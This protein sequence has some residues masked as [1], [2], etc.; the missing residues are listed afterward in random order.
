[1]WIK[2]MQPHPWVTHARSPLNLWLILVPSKFTTVDSLRMSYP[3]LEK[4]IHRFFGLSIY[5]EDRPLPPIYG[6]L[7][8]GLIQPFEP[9]FGLLSTAGG[10]FPQFLDSYP[11]FGGSKKGYCLDNTPHIWANR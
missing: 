3:Q 10:T 6:G 5:W 2:G 1:M 7:V 8:L 9:T 11:Q 4:V